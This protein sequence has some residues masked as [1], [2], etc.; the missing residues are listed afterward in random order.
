MVWRQ[1][2]SLNITNN[3]VTT[4]ISIYGAKKPVG[5]NPVLPSFIS[6]NLK[7]GESVEKLQE[8]F[9]IDKY[10]N[11]KINNVELKTI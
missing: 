3:F 11:P 1:A 9:P 5:A 7:H 2:Y 10:A 6:A 4:Y 8:N